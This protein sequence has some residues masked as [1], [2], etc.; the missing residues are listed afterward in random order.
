MVIAAELEPSNMEGAAM[1]VGVRYWVDVEERAQHLLGVGAAVSDTRAGEKVRFRL[2]VWTPGSYLVRE[3]S[4][5][6]QDEKAFDGQRQPLKVVQTDKRTWEV[7]A[8]DSGVMLQY[9]VYCNEL[10]VRT[11]HANSSHVFI[12]PAATFCAVEGRESMAAEIDFCIPQSWRTFTSLEAGPRE[13]SFVAR[14]FDELVDSPMELGPHAHLEFSAAGAPHTFAVWGN[15]DWDLARICGDTAQIVEEAARIFGGTVPYARYL[16]VLH[17]AA[18]AR[19]GLEHLASCILGWSPTRFRALTDY[20]DFL[21]LVAHEF[22]HVWNIKRIRPKVLG[23]FDYGSENY[24]RTLWLHEGGTV[25]YDGIIPVRAGVVRVSTWLADLAD[26]IKRMEQTPGRFHE[27]A[28]DASF[29]AWVKLYRPHEHSHNTTISYYNKGELICLCLDAEIRKQTGHASSL[30]AAMAHLYALT[31]PPKPGY[32]ET[33]LI[34]LLEEATGT[35]LRSFADRFVFGTEDPPLADALAFYGLELTRITPEPKPGHPRGGW[36][37]IQTQRTDGLL[38]V[39]KVDEGS[40]AWT[41][42][43]GA[44]DAIVAINGRRVRMDELDARI[45]LFEPGEEL[46]LTLFHLDELVERRVTL[47]ERPPSDYKVAPVSAPTDAQ[48]AAFQALCGKP[49]P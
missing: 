36:L 4:R 47:G 32:D 24:T 13:G 37:G 42:G 28:A 30:D 6:I 11:N 33:A 3:Y 40:P 16:F 35:S 26:S 45:R 23:P 44:G 38:Q 20:E 29:N 41:A 22:F 10:S 14:D 39:S 17:S 19:G 7:T 15:G 25:Y 43:V 18:G 48:Q 2:P 9:R 46:V 49:L 27:S 34:G 12:L 5:L 31:A 8:G 21:R 1:K